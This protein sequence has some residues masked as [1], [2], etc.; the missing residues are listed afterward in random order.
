MFEKLRVLEHDIIPYYSKS[1]CQIQNLHK[2]CGGGGS[3]LTKEEIN[4]LQHEKQHM[5]FS[6]YYVYFTSAAQNPS[7]LIKSG[8]ET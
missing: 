8:I 1:I 3:P 2:R 6:A 5:Y 7:V 4:I